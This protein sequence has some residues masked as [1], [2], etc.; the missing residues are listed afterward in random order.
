MTPTGGV[1]S[2]Q[3]V[4]GSGT[5]TATSI[6]ATA[7]GRAYLAATYTGALRAGTVTR[8]SGSRDSAIVRVGASIE[9]ASWLGDP[10]SFSD[11]VIGDLA[12]SSTGDILA[13]GFFLGS[14]SAASD[15][16]T[17]TPIG[18]ALGGRDGFVV[19]IAATTGVVTAPPVWRFGGTADD[20]LAAIATDSGGNVLVGGWFQSASVSTPAGTMTRTTTGTTTSD[21]MFFMLDDATVTWQRRFGTS[22][23]NN[24]TGV[25]CSETAHLAVAGAIS[26]QAQIDDRRTV[27]SAGGDDG[28][29]S[30]FDTP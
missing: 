17:F 21:G 30:V 2:T 25:A 4:A 22:G 13:T 20:S 26:G 18:N 23:T 6:A 24:V 12:V 16:G 14:L 3:L 8:T 27:T 10:V 5:C 19:Q 9:G 28:F 15:A 7:D 29:L 1:Q 11:A